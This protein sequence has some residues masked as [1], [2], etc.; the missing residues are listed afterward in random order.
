MTT[1]VNLLYYLLSR[2]GAVTVNGTTGQD[3]GAAVSHKQAPRHAHGSWEVRGCVQ[4][5][6]ASC[7][8]FAW[9]T[10]RLKLALSTSSSHVPVLLP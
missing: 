7:D 2:A 10:C 3:E 5:L 4:W 6:T 9:A 8:W 1:Q